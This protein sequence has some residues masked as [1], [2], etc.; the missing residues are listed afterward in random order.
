MGLEHY[1]SLLD[2]ASSLSEQQPGLSLLRSLRCCCC[3]VAKSSQTLCDPMDCSTPGSPVLQLSPGACSNLCPLSLRW[4]G[5]RASQDRGS[6]LG[7]Q[8][9]AVAKTL[10]SRPPPWRKGFPSHFKTEKH[11]VLL[12]LSKTS[13][14]FPRGEKS[15]WLWGP[16]GSFPMQSLPLFNSCN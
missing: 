1:D 9:T 7:S 5:Q 13:S 8:M 2:E 4:G 16:R 14:V 15:E 11:L 3:S 10:P 6:K 12:H